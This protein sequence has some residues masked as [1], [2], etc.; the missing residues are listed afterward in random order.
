MSIAGYSAFFQC[1]S[2]NWGTI[3]VI[4]DEFDNRT[5]PET[6]AAAIIN[7]AQPPVSREGLELPGCRLRRT[8]GARPGPVR[9]LPAANRG[10]HRPGPAGPPGSDRHDRPEGQRPARPGPRL[11]HVQRQHAAAVPGYR[12]GSR[13]GDGRVAGGRD[14]HAQRQHGLGVRQPVQRVR[15]HLAGQHPGRG[16]LP[17]ERG[18]P[19]APRGPQ[20]S[21]AAGAAGRVAPGARSTAGRSSSCATTT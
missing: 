18:E 7:E 20:P 11:H 16:R 17:Q 21:G 4:L 8:A 3:F 14:Q 5:T 15:P 6:Q 2:S 19:Q 1:D 10:P 9:R 13:Q 12:P